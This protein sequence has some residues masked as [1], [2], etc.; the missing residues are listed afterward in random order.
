[1]T[2]IPGKGTDGTGFGW[3]LEVRVHDHASGMAP[4]YTFREHLTHFSN[5]KSFMFF[6]QW[7]W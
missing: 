5:V 3:V 6:L 7:S 4:I 2:S 1:M